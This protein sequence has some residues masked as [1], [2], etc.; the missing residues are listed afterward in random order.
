MKNRISVIQGDITKQQV[1]AIVNTT[2][3]YFSGSSV[4]D[5]AI[6]SA[7]GSQLREECDRLIGSVRSE[8]KITSGYNLPARWI[9]HI[10]A[11]LWQKGNNEDRM[12]AVAECYRNCLALAEEY[13]I[14]TIAFPAISRS[15]LGFPRRTAARIAV[16]EV[17]VFLK[18]NNSVEKVVFVCLEEKYYYHY[19]NAVNEIIEEG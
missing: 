16:G 7:A 1:D 6:H 11:P 8:V 19:L 13:S 17:K 14:K 4:V 18:R 9:I 12:L 3:P 2:D 15:M 10:V 5:E